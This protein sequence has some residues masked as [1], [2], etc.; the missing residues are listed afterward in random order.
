MKTQLALALALSACVAD[1][2][3]DADLDQVT[4]ASTTCRLVR[5][6]T[7]SSGAYRWDVT[8][9]FDGSDFVDERRIG[10]GF[11]R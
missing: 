7:H 4:E 11:Y 9:D 3:L 6:Y 8:T 10:G 1:D 2:D 5:H